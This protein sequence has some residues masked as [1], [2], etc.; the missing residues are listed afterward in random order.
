MKWLEIGKVDFNKNMCIINLLE[1]YEKALKHLDLFSHC[2]LYFVLEDKIEVLIGE[3]LEVNE[4][5]GRLDLALYLSE[6]KDDFL[7]IAKMLVDIKPYFPAEEVIFEA[8][9]STEKFTISNNNQFIGTYKMYGHRFVI[10]FYD[11]AI[12]AK[13]IANI[14][15]GDYIRILWWFHRFDKDHF[16]KN[17]RCHPPYNQAP[18]TGIFASRSPVRPNPLGSTLVQVKCIDVDHAYIEVEGFDGFLGTEIIQVMS[19]NPL[20]ESLEKVKLPDWISHWTNYK[21]FSGERVIEKPHINLEKK[22]HF[23]DE[24]FKLCPQLEKEEDSEKEIK[25]NEIKIHNAHIHNLKNI[26]VTIPKNEITLI[27]GVSGSGKSSLAFDTLYVESQRQFVDL[28]LS[29]P[30]LSNSLRETYVEKITGLQPAIVIKQKS[31]GLNPRSTL[32]SVTKISDLLR[33]IYSTI[34]IR[35]CPN[36]HSEVDRSNICSDCGQILFDITPQHFSYNHPDYM[37]PRCKGLGLEISIDKETIVENKDRSLLDSASTLYGDLRKHRKK[38]NANWMRG[39]ILALAEDM[40]VDLELA[41]KD[42]PEAFKK[43]FYFGSSGREVSLSYE[44]SKGR[45]GI[46]KRPVEGAVN[47]LERLMKDTK[48]TNIGAQAERYISKKTCSLCQGDRLTAEGRLAHIM[49][50]SYPEVMKMTLLNLRIWCHGVYQRLT[51]ENQNKSRRL[52]MKLNERLKRMEGVGLTYL[53]LDRSV[54]SLSGGESQRLKLATQFGIG[55]SNILYIM[56]EPSKGLHPKDYGFLMDVLLDLKNQNNT[57]VLVEHKR[58]FLK[59]A[60]LHLKLG[61]KA[62]QY[63]GA[64]I[65]VEEKKAIEEATKNQEKYDEDYDFNVLA[66]SNLERSCSYIEMMGVKTNNLKDLKVKIPKGKITAVIGVSGSGKSSLV[67]KTLYPAAMKLLGKT[68]EDGGDYE[69]IRGLESFSEICYVNQNPIGSNARSTPGTY[70]GVFDLIRKCYADTPQAKDKKLSK[71][72]FSFN[73]KHGQC[74]A[75][76]GLGLIAV[77]MHYMDDLM[78]ACNKCLGKRYSKEVLAIKRKNYSIGDILDLE[79]RDLIEIF[80][81]E[82]E[83][84]GQLSWLQAVGLAYIKLGQSGSTLS[85]GEAQRI[86]LAKELSKGGTKQALYILD[87]PTSGLHEEDIKRIIDVLSYLREKGATILVIEHHPMMIR[88]CDYIIELGPEGGMLG[89]EIIRTG[90]QIK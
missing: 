15:S 32:G 77:N 51:E 86:K 39:E 27:T 1:G 70:T 54:P 36:C 55:L 67:S 8:E 83:I 25:E 57:V 60:D 85:G 14:K 5:K 74:S 10:E 65:A 24:D 2:L 53:S 80:K 90:F 79:V 23:S 12:E 89:G 22:I 64:L 63:G 21:S 29:N 31:L 3:I 50:Y 37:C 58:S 34:S 26:T 7:S 62:G 88:S 81:E 78:V 75:C 46:I 13:K 72:F 30:M 66:D 43:E 68:V 44:N 84:L 82:E 33:L 45:S 87:E 71:E 16:R 19:Y 48:S 69:Y 38:P 18:E 59:I 52:F 6:E 11:H 42:L 76:K 73:S 41:F 20:L 9:T 4:K 61:P 35:I 49:G 56:D 28:L 17:R 47:L 40:K